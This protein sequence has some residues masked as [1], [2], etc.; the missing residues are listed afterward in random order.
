[1]LGIRLRPCSGVCRMVQ[2]YQKQIVVWNV[3]N[4]ADVPLVRD[5]HQTRLVTHTFVSLPE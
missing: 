3:M 4:S 5:I 2:K 1:M